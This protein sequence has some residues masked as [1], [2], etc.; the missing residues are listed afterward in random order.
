[1]IRSIFEATKVP[2]TK[3]QLHEMY[4]E[5][6]R[7]VSSVTKEEGVSLRVVNLKTKRTLSEHVE[8]VRDEERHRITIGNNELAK[9]FTGKENE[10]DESELKIFYSDAENFY[11]KTFLFVPHAKTKQFSPEETMFLK[12]IASQCEIMFLL[13]NSKYYKG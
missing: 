3:S 7:I 11:I 13:F 4:N 12:A 6:L 9:Q 2:S 8:L 1:M 5:L 10:I